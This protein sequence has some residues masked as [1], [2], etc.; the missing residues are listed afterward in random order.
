M[1]SKTT[2]KQSDCIAMS[3]LFRKLKLVIQLK[4][5]T[6]SRIQ[7]YSLQHSTAVFLRI[8]LKASILRKNIISC[9]IDSKIQKSTSWH[10]SFSTND[11]LVP[12]FISSAMNYHKWRLFSYASINSLWMKLNS[13]LSLNRNAG[14][15]II[16]RGLVLNMYVIM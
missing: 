14:K 5:Q 8:Q 7:S 10:A 13:I 3:Y 15:I 16:R 11:I 12:K 1:V 4:P 9:Y 2:G 6:I